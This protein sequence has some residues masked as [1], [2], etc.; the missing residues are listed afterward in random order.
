MWGT[1]RNIEGQLGLGNNTNQ[2]TLT[3]V[4]SDNNWSNICGAGLF[5]AAIKTDGTLWTSGNNMFGQLGDG[6]YNN[7][8]VFAQVGT[9]TNWSKIY[10]T[11]ASLCAIKNDGTLWFCGY[12]GNGNSGDGTIILNNTGIT[13]LQQVGTDT[14]WKIVKFG[15]NQVIGL[16]QNGTIWTWGDN[17]QGQLGDGTLNSHYFPTQLG[18]DTDW[19]D[20]MTSA[21]ILALKTNGTLWSWGS[22]SKG[23]LGDGTMINRLSPNQ[24]GTDTNWINIISVRSPSIESAILLFGHAVKT[25][26]INIINDNRRNLLYNSPSGI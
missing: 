11:N 21:S 2:F 22:N 12:N 14:D 4:G 9:D 26:F 15:T 10:A 13:T 23:N 5:N 24:I 3:Q 6:T 18:T 1:G 17:F 8:N 20:I 16:K 19:K 25:F 7:R